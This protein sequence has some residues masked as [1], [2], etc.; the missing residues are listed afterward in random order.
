MVADDVACPYPAGRLGPYS[1][2]GSCG[3]ATN[4]AALFR[5]FC[6]SVQANHSESPVALFTI[7]KGD[8]TF[9]LAIG[10]ALGVANEAADRS[11]A[12]LLNS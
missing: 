8:P 6:E 3:A 5:L 10:F 7:R 9:Q 12:F 2:S 1:L 4:V 11:W